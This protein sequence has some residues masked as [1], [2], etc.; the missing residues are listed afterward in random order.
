MKISLRKTFG[1][2]G[3]MHTFFSYFNNEGRTLEL[4]YFNFNNSNSYNSQYFLFFESEESLNQQ[5]FYLNSI[6]FKA[7]QTKKTCTAS[8]KLVGVC[9]SPFGKMHFFLNIFRLG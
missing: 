8:R 7:F 9:L 3:I 4:D 1:V 2:Y 6:L 5:D